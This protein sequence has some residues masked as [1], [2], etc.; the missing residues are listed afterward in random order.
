MII[1]TSSGTYLAKY[2]IL[3]TFSGFGYL[4]PPKS[5][6]GVQLGYINTT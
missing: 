1:F 5:G 3:S 6:S 4:I 2:I